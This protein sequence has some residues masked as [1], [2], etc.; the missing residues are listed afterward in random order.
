ML[1]DY[2]YIL[3]DF[4]TSIDLDPKFPFTWF[5]RAFILSKLGRYDEAIS[6]LDKAIELQPDFAE[7]YFNRGLIKIYQ[8]DT[9]GGAIDLSKAGELGIQDAYNVIKRYCN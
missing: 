9:E 6:N 8:D 3:D 4:Q 1:T 2:Q 5:N 7:A